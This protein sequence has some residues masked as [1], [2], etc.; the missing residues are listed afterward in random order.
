MEVLSVV[1]NIDLEALILKSLN[2][3]RNDRSDLVIKIDNVYYVNIIHG[4]QLFPS[5]MMLRLLSVKFSGLKKKI[6]EIHPEIYKIAFGG[7]DETYIVISV[8]FNT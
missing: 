4:L 3:I 7:M 2:I 8:I 5:E 1:S 6:L